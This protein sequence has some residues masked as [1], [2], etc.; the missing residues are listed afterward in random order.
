VARPILGDAIVIPEA[1]SDL[2]AL[3]ATVPEVLGLR[4]DPDTR[5]R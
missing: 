3:I 1:S 5:L 4:E 2:R